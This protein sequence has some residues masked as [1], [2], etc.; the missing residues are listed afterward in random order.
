MLHST[1]VSA[2]AQEGWYKD[3]VFGN[4]TLLNIDSR[5]NKVY[6][7]YYEYVEQNTTKKDEYF[8]YKNTGEF[9]Q[10]LVSVKDLLV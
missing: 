10:W 1:G 8:I 3:A 9:T 6:H 7:K 5:G 2:V 4:Y